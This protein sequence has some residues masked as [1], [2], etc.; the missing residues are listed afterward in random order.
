A[1][2]KNWLD[3]AVDYFEKAK[4]ILEPIQN[5]KIIGHERLTKNVYKTTFEEGQSIIV[6]YNREEVEID[7]YILEPRSYKIEK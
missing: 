5:Q 6:N 4:E 1:Y 2:Y 3:E 7:N